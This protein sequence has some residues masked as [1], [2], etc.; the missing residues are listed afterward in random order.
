MINEGPTYLEC[1][2][3]EG[4]RLAELRPRCHHSQ[5]DLQAMVLIVRMLAQ[6][7]DVTIADAEGCLARLR[8]AVETGVYPDELLRLA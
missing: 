6:G 8:I 5:G 4:T 1:L 3:A 2:L 7:Y